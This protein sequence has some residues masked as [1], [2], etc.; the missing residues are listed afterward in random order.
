MPRIFCAALAICIC[1]PPAANAQAPRTAIQNAFEDAVLSEMGGAGSAGTGAAARTAPRIVNGIPVT[2]TADRWN[3]V[4][5]LQFGGAHRCGGA[6]LAPEFARDSFG[7]LVIGLWQSNPGRPPDYFVTAAHCMFSPEG[8]LLFPDDIAVY[9]G[10]PA[11]DATNATIRPVRGFRIHEAYDERTLE[12]DIAVL[13]LGPATQTAGEGTTA[14]SLPTLRDGFDYQIPNAAI[15]I[16]GWGRTFEGGPVSDELLQARVPYADQDRCRDN[17]ARIG[18][19]IPEGSFCAG[20]SSGGVDSC[21]GDSGGPATFQHT[22][23]LGAAVGE[24][25]LVGVVSFGIGCARNG[26]QGIY[27]DVLSRTGWLTRTVL[28]IQRARR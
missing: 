9:S 1:L 11:P 17:Y 6:F 21:Q 3:F 7:N 16:R 18:A 10:S 25:M 22:N 19:R 12:N 2:Q 20:F 23:I 24:T 4:G 14:L 13:E 28:S 5:S 26:L 8:D 27:T 15:M